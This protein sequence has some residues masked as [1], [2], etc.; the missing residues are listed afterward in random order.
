VL[1]DLAAAVAIRWV[2][3]TDWHFLPGIMVVT[4]VLSILAMIAL[5]FVSTERALRQPAAPRLR[6]ENGG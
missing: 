2:F 3:H 1:G 6:L 5:G 4:V